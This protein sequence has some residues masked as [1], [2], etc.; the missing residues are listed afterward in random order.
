MTLSKA[1]STTRF[2][3][4]AAVVASVVSCG[5]TPMQQQEQSTSSVTEYTPSDRRV[6]ILGGNDPT[7]EVDTK[8]WEMSGSAGGQVLYVGRPH[9]CR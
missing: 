7:Y 3:L 4:L 9:D 5:R 2:G 1:S 8:I 6:V